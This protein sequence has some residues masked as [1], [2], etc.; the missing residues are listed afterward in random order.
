MSERHLSLI[1]PIARWAAWAPGLESPEQW[2]EWAQSRAQPSGTGAPALSFVDPMLRRRLGKTARMAL[3]VAHQCLPEN[4]PMR[5]VF[6]SR[7]GEL[8]RTVGMLR[9]LAQGQDISPTEFALSVHNAAA[10]VY[11]IAR[12][13]RSASTSIVAG[14]E[15]FAYGLVEAATQWLADRSHPVLFVYSDEPVPDEY[16]TFVSMPEHAHAVAILLAEP[17][18]MTATI[19]FS[20]ERAGRTPTAEMQSLSFLRAVLRHDTDAA[21]SA[22]RGTWHW[23]VVPDS[24]SSPD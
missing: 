16:R 5:T 10:G 24:V 9:Q 3:H 13:D 18:D 23:H 11:S 6:S 17:A 22:D 4:A 20:A 21:W 14:A 7:H 12:A 8:H 1:L 15:T 19:K 2:R